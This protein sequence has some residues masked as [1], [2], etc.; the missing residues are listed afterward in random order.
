MPYIRMLPDP[1]MNYTLKRPLLDGT[2]PAWMKEM[3]A[4]ASRIKDYES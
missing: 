2:S 3:G 1:G 4:V